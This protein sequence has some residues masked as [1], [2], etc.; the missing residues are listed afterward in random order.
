M[1]SRIF[2]NTLSAARPKGFVHETSSPILLKEERTHG[3]EIVP[4]WLLHRR[5]FCRLFVAPHWHEEIEI[6]Y[7]QE[8][9]FILEANMSAIRSIREA[10]YFIRSGELHRIFSANRCAE[11]AVV[12]SL[13]TCL[14]FYPM[15]LRRDGC[16]DRSQTIHCCCRAASIQQIPAF[17]QV[18]SNTRK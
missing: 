3:S 9:H 1:N 13:R 11:S 6:V 15:T 18:L 7:F 17:G 10:I 12:F 14:R 16:S 5:C 2:C 8:G 4:L